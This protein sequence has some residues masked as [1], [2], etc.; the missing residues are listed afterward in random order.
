MRCF[1]EGKYP[2]LYLKTF[3]LFFGG[4][5]EVGWWGGG[6]GWGGEETREKVQFLTMRKFIPYFLGYKAGLFPSKT[7]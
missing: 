6:G 1:K 4:W 3:V 7:I 5:G 2:V